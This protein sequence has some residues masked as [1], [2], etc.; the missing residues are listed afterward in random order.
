MEREARLQGILHISQK[1]SSFGECVFY[2]RTYSESLVNVATV[3][4][5]RVDDE[6]DCYVLKGMDLVIRRAGEKE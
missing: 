3:A 6:V 1:P 5:V 4:A 2:P